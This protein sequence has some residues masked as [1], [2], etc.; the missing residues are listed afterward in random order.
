MKTCLRIRAGLRHSAPRVVDRGVVEAPAYDAV[1]VP[2]DMST[3]TIRFSP[4]NTQVS[5]VSMESVD[6]VVV[7]SPVS[8]VMPVVELDM[9]QRRASLRYSTHRG[10]RCRT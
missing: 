3:I 10:R 8:D 5:S 4:L 2:S 9:L 6:R 1:V 7:E